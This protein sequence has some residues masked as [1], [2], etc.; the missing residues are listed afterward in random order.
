MSNV[1]VVTG[2]SGAGRSEFAK[3]LEDLGWFVID[4]VPA[5]L[6]SKLADLAGAPETPWERVAFTLR[7]D[8]YEGETLT[9]LED[10]RSKQEDLQVVFLDCSTETLLQRYEDTRRP[11]P[12]GDERGLEEAISSERSALEPVRS[13]ANIIIDT[14]DLNVHD[15]RRKVEGLFGEVHD[16]PM[17]VLLTSFGFKH[18]TPRDA[19]M[20]FDCRFLPNPHWEETLRPLTGLDHPVREYVENQSMT[21]PFL[22]Q[23]KDMLDLLLPVYAAGGH[24]FFSL[25]FGCTGGRHRSVAITEIIREHLIESGF[26]PLITHRDIK[27]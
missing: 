12:F 23:L 26:D 15:L 16:R 9:A 13:E 7:F 17:R 5:D 6:I 18:G 27:Q 21:E 22:K 14:S 25:A 20:V 24:T 10:L 1:L 19:S 2:L 11:H 3:D 8:S 4:R